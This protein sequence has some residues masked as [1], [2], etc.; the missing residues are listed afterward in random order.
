MSIP[1]LSTSIHKQPYYCKSANP[2]M[3]FKHCQGIK[4][5]GSSLCDDLTGRI[6]GLFW[7]SLI[8]F[9]IICNE[10]FKM[11]I[12]IASR[13]MPIIPQ[14]SSVSQFIRRLLQDRKSSKC[15]LLSRMSHNLKLLK[16]WSNN[17]PVREIGHLGISE[18]GKEL[19]VTLTKQQE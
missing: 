16:G 11:K 17:M 5:G 2:L 6:T 3:Y 15:L 4:S 1:M 13:H 19:Y 14:L 12:T 8:T 18:K 10:T 7:D 9:K